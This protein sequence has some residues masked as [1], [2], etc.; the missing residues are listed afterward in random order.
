[1]VKYKVLFKRICGKWKMHQ[2]NCNLTV[3]VM[4]KNFPSEFSVVRDENIFI[5]K[6]FSVLSFQFSL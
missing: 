4:V 1:M 5:R 3:N 6:V 2:E